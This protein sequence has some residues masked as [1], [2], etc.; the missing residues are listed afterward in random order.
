MVFREMLRDH[1]AVGVALSGLR[2]VI[3]IEAAKKCERPDRP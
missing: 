2:V 1:P 3:S